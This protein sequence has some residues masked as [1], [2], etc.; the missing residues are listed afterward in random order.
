MF[1]TGLPA[2]SKPLSYRKQYQHNVIQLAKIERIELKGNFK[3]CLI[4]LLYDNSISG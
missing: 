3:V 2:C 1:G 4:G